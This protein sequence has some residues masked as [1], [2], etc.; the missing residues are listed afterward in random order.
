MQ[1]AD[2]TMIFS[3]G[4]NESLRNLKGVLM[5]FERVSRMRINFHKSEYIPMNID[6]AR[7]HEIAPV[8]KCHVGNFPLRYLGIPLHFV[9]IS[10][11]QIFGVRS[12]KT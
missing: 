1:Y 2:D 9:S 4:S 7:C 5:L 11:H 10:H 3:F 6:E 12:E 8:L